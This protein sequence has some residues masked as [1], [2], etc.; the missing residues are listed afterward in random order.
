MAWGARGLGRLEAGVNTARREA[1]Q[2]ML[3]RGFRTVVQ[4]VAMHRPDEAGYNRPDV[5]LMDDWR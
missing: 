2:R 1:Y 5:F 3:A 4:G